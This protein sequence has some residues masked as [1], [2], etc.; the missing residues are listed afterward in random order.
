MALI[1]NG[2]HQLCG[3][4]RFDGAFGAA[5]LRDQF[6]KR[7]RFK[8]FDS[9]THAVSG[10]TNKSSIP[11]GARHP[12]AWRMGTKA[13][14][15]S[16][17]NEAEGDCSLSLSLAAG[18]NISGLAEGTTPTAEATLQLVVSMVASALGEATTSANLNAA[19]GLSGSAAGVATNN[20]IISALAWAIGQAD[21]EAT[22]TLVSYATGQLQ[23]NITPFT[24][25]SPEG[26]AAAVWNSLL[27]NY[28]DAGTA[29]N[30]LTNAG[31]GG[32]PWSAIIENGMTAE[33]VLRVMAS[34]LAG[35]VSGAG[36]GTETFVGLDGVTNRVIS[37]VDNDGNRSSVTVDGT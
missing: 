12:I 18:R 4:S 10:V 32:N 14:S 23:G 19:L 13:G 11:S 31:A 5:S 7:G 24:E 21:G 2:S 30:A 27:I 35:K 9:G 6:D 20:A 36:T 8:N 37:S 29:G 3:L 25:L 1:R 22:A 16:S 34:V 33:E 28:Q 26:L 15:L 17:T